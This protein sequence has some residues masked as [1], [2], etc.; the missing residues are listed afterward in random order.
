LNTFPLDGLT[1]LSAL[2]WVVEACVVEGST[3]VSAGAASS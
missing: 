2:S 3:L 1:D